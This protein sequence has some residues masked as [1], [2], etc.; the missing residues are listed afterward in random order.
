[1]AEDGNQEEDEEGE[2]QHYRKHHQCC[3]QEKA[4]ECVKANKPI[5][6]KGFDQEENDGRNEGHISQHGREL[7]IEA[8]G[9]AENGRASCDRTAATGAETGIVRHF[10]TTPAARDRHSSFP[11]TSLLPEPPCNQSGTIRVDCQGS[12]ENCL[13]IG[14]SLE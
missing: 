5:F 2:S 7:V 11:R 13:Q 12:P 1:M 10:D 3:P 4:L 8:A 9:C 6:V 14:M